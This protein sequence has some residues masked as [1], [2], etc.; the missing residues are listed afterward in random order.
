MWYECGLVEVEQ[1]A[2]DGMPGASSLA[3]DL[4]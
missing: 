2:V 1:H 4:L 3:S